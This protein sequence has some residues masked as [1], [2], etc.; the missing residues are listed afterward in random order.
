MGP[1]NH[2]KQL[3]SGK[4]RSETTAFKDGILIYI[5]TVSLKIVIE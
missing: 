4:Y 3:C 5:V 1:K 2:A